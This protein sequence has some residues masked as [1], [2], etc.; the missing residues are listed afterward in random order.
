MAITLSNSFDLV[1]VDVPLSFNIRTLVHLTMKT[2]NDSFT[3]VLSCFFIF[4]LTTYISGLW[5]R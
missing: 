5:L 2:I 3:P 4:L 1:V